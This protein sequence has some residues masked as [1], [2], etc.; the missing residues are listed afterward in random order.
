M[1]TKTTIELN[2]EH[3]TIT[4]NEYL[5]GLKTQLGGTCEDASDK[6]AW[7][8]FETKGAAADFKMHANIVCSGIATESDLD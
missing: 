7:F 2:Y 5:M 4:Q 3:L 6:S 1:T 8:S